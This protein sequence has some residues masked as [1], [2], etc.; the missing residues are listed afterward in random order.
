VKI[1]SEALNLAMVTDKFD[2]DTFDENVDIEQPVEKDDEAASSESDEKN[3][4]P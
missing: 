1:N 4:Q 2:A 3:M